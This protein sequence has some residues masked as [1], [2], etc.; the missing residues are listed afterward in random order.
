VRWLPL[1]K[2]GGEV[3]PEADKAA[4]RQYKTDFLHKKRYP[5]YALLG[6]FLG[7]FLKHNY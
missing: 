5:V 4:N 1:C 3:C 6:L 7:R 2:P